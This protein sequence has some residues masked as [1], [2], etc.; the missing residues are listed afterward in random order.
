[1]VLSLCTYT[2]KPNYARGVF[3]VGVVFVAPSIDAGIHHRRP[4]F[5]GLMVRCVRANTLIER[6]SVGHTHI[7]RS[8]S[9]SSGN[10]G[11]GNSII[12]SDIGSSSSSTWLSVDDLRLEVRS[13]P[14]AQFVCLLLLFCVCARAGF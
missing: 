6:G 2:H 10:S 7:L 1:M 11:D 5:P 3:P 12:I 13:C 14:T 8:R 9:S 4:V